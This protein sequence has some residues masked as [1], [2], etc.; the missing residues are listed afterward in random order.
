MSSTGIAPAA[1]PSRTIVGPICTS[2]GFRYW[3]LACFRDAIIAVPQ[4]FLIGVAMSYSSEIRRQL[5]IGPKQWIMD[6]VTGPGRGLRK[7][8]PAQL[9]RTPDSLLRAKPNIVIPISDLR[10][11]VFRS[12]MASRAGLIGMP[13]I[14][15]EWKAGKKQVYGMTMVDLDK[16]SVQLSEMYPDL[17]K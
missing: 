15:V 12:T 11:I 13:E 8:I 7:K 6:M 17:C 4:P 1:A 9:E 10:S 2:F 16:A 3:Y 5:F 14:I